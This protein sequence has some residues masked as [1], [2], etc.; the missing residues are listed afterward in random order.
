MPDL[1]LC[2]AQGTTTRVSTL[3]RTGRGLLLE[4]GDTGTT[5]PRVAGVDRI[6]ARPTEAAGSDATPGIG[7]DTGAAPEVDRILIRPDGYVCWAGAGPHASPDSA[8]ERWF[9]AATV[10]TSSGQ[11]LQAGT[12]DTLA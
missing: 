3:L 9:G 5:E 12:L 7:T 6:I 10:P 11:G 2:T 8:I 1:D 4:L